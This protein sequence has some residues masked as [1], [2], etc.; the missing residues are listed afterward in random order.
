[1]AD[2]KDRVVSYRK[3]EW[4]IGHPGSISLM[5]CVNEAMKKCPKAAQRIVQY[6]GQLLTLAKHK[7]E[8]NEGVFVHITADTPGESASV[9]PRHSEPVDEIDVGTTPPPEHAEFMDGDAFLY[10]R[11]NDLFLCTTSLQEQIVQYF[12][13][14]YFK[15]AAIR[16]D[17]TRFVFM[18][19][20]DISQLKLL[21]KEGVR[22]VEL[23]AT[24]FEATAHYQARKD[25]AYG[26]LGK[27]GK[28]IKPLMGANE[29]DVNQD[30]L[31]VM[32]SLK[33]DGRRSG[34]KVGAKRIED[35][36]AHLVNQ[37]KTG[38]EFVIVTR[39]GK[40]ITPKET[41]VRSHV[42]I[43]AA[44]KSVAVDK[45]WREL[46]SFYLSLADSGILE[47]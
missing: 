32:L 37:K 7:R 16:D 24:V 3:V 13:V 21:R 31:R 18:K 28:A 45:A 8:A 12:L 4:N 19:V 22:E 27:I 43:D 11:G 5:A 23:S 40:R 47:Q 14:E 25:Q 34:V 1:M 35:F 9:V 2:K 15:A 42:K 36:A 17:S 30:G 44:G 29:H 38:D 46:R 10:I 6:N 33:T 26:V 39:R 41:F 20:A